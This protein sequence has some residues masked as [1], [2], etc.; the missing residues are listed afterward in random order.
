[1]SA[2]LN[3]P[4]VN[5]MAI[6]SKHKPQAAIVSCCTDALAAEFLGMPPVNSKK[7]VCN[8]LQPWAHKW[9]YLTNSLNTVTQAYNLYQLVRCQQKSVTDN[10]A[11]MEANKN[12][13]DEFG[14]LLDA[15]IQ[16]VL[17]VNWAPLLDSLMMQP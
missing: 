1:M 7:H 16:L 6:R 4:L 5:I 9:A 2:D 17:R 14:V 10:V 12:S 11:L 8:L 15:A 13:A 3:K